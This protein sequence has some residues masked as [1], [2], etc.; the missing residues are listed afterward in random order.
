V[1]AIFLFTLRPNG[2]LDY[3]RNISLPGNPLEVEVVSSDR[4]VIA[5][6]PARAG[7]Y[8]LSKSLLKVERVGQ[9]Y[10]VADGLIGPVPDLGEHETDLAE[11]E[12]QTLLFNAENLRKTD[13]EEGLA[14]AE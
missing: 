14:E 7:E 3:V 9:D 13:S 5:V 11:E 1:P 2:T 12:L 6:E 8:D 4:L 10:E